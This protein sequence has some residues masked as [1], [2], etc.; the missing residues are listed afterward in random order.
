M[1]I[2]MDS[3]FIELAELRSHKPNYTCF[4]GHVMAL[5]GRSGK[6]TARTGINNLSGLTLFEQRQHCPRH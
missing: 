3:Y 2:V 5:V 4:G 6:D 1:G